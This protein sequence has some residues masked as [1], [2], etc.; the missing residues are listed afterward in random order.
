ML[1]KIEGQGCEITVEADDIKELLRQVSSVQEVMA[2]RSCKLCGEENNLRFN[3]RKVEAFEFFALHC[4][5]CNAE[6]SFGQRKD[7][8]GLFPKDWSRYK[9]TESDDAPF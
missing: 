5:A 6:L 9:Q 7:G 3:V 4:N 8:S 2:K 1:A